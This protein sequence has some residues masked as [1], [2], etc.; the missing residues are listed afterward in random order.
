MDLQSLFDDGDEYVGRDRGPD[1]RLHGV[2]R[3]AVELLD[4]QMLFDPL[5][6]E[7]D[8]PTAAIQFGD[9]Q[10]YTKLFVRNTS[11]LPVLGSLN[12]IRRSGVSKSWLE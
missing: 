11:R 6:E 8:L 5:E 7:F 12:R 10:G 3:R 9:R 1:L 2:F 4:P